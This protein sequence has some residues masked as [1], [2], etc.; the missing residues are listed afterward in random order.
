MPLPGPC[1]LPL[2]VQEQVPQ[3]PSRQSWAN[4]I[5]SSPLSVISSFTT[6]SSS[7]N[8]MSGFTFA[9]GY[10]TNLPG[11]AGPAWRQTRRVTEKSF[12][13]VGATM[14]GFLGLLVG[15]DAHLSELVVEG[16]GVAQRG[17]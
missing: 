1:G 13:E 4:A 6:S 16:F 2:M 10:S 12:L 14:G 15:A 8:D 11:A 5:G 7:R 17:L 9:A 3:M